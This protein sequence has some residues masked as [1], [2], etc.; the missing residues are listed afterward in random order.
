MQ[1]LSMGMT[2]ASFSDTQ[3]DICVLLGGKGN[4]K[5]S[6]NVWLNKQI[7]YIV[8]FFF[9]FYNLIPTEQKKNEMMQAKG[10]ES[11][12]VEEVQEGNT[13]YHS[14]SYLALFLPFC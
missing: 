1:I 5:T 6:G 13:L 4:G 9:P 14:V 3:W 7:E 8:L 12:M 11:E 10:W 2:S